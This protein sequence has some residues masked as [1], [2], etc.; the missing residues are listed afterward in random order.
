MR[1]TLIPTGFVLHGLRDELRELLGLLFRV[2]P[3]VPQVIL[4]LFPPLL[5]L[6]QLGAQLHD[7]LLQGV[8][9]ALGLGAALQ[10]LYD[11][12]GGLNVPARVGWSTSTILFFSSL[13]SRKIFE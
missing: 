4:Q 13:H 7:A 3:R 5:R 6:L 1:V 8:D 9:A 2:L 10:L 11:A 12:R